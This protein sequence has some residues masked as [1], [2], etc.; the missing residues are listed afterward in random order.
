MNS[1]APDSRPSSIPRTFRH[2][3]AHSVPPL[4]YD[5]ERLN[6]SPT[7]KSSAP[8]PWQSL[9]VGASERL[10]FLR[11]S[12][13]LADLTIAFPG[14]ERTVQV[15]KLMLSMSS[16]VFNAMLNGH[17]AEGNYLVLQDDLPQ[18]FEWILEYLY[19]DKKDLPG[20]VGATQVYQLADKYQMEPLCRMCSKYLLGVVEV[21][22]LPYVFNLAVLLNNDALLYSC[23]TIITL[24]SDEVLSS[25]DLGVLSRAAMS[26][27]VR[28]PRLGPSSELIL[29]KGLLNWSRTQ[30][31]HDMRAIRQN[32]VPF[33]TDLRFLTMSEE[34]FINHVVPSG[35]FGSDES[36]AVLG[37]MRKV[38]GAKM[39]LLAP[40][41]STSSRPQHVR[42]VQ[43]LR[44][45]KSAR[46]SLSLVYRNTKE[47]TMVDALEVT[48]PVHIRQF[49]SMG[50]IDLDPSIVRVLDSKGMTIAQGTW[51]GLGCKFYKPFVLY[52]DMKYT[53]KVL[54]VRG[55]SSYDEDEPLKVWDGWADVVFS[56]HLF[57]SHL[58][59]EFLEA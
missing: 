36:D 56:A 46:G 2:T 40:C 49:L 16:P 6:I 22:N 52:P 23:S 12:G 38:Q 43:L 51:K 24:W 45:P 44:K 41:L 19:K 7:A 37:V 5:L 25:P 57:Y 32:M 54:T 13:E 21:S 55:L 3:G 8:K 47:Q 18:A 26:K 33:L 20:A 27:L 14:Q 30:Q 58:V 31:G 48:Y 39:P 1:Q 11:D 59:I 9:L 17:L 35:V 4:T 28:H 42:R 15:H 10:A 34:D 50:F 29:Y 53:I